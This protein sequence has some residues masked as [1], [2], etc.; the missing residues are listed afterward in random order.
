MQY[1]TVPEMEERAHSDPVAWAIEPQIH[2]PS[3][4]PS[5]VKTFLPL[6]REIP[7]WGLQFA[8]LAGNQFP[9]PAWRRLTGTAWGLT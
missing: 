5:E 7:D 8:T 6:L 3:H 4:N 1:G 2:L 9:F